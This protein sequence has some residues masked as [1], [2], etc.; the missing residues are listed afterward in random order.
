MS[1][2]T[3]LL[4]IV[5]A[6]TAVQFVA[7]SLRNLRD[8]VRL[9]PIWN[10]TPSMVRDHKTVPLSFIGGDTVLATVITY[11]YGRLWIRPSAKKQVA[12]C[13]QIVFL[14]RDRTARDRGDAVEAGGLI[15][16]I[17]SEG[18]NSRH[19]RRSARRCTIGS[20]LVLAMLFPTQDRSQFETPVRCITVRARARSARDKLERVPTRVIEWEIIYPAGIGTIMD[21]SLEGHEVRPDTFWLVSKERTL[22]AGDH[23]RLRSGGVFY[24]HGSSRLRGFL[25]LCVMSCFKLAMGLLALMTTGILLSVTDSYLTILVLSV[26]IPLF[27]VYRLF[28]YVLEQELPERFKSQAPTVRQKVRVFGMW[29]TTVYR[30]LEWHGSTRRSLAIGN[31]IRGVGF[32]QRFNFMCWEPLVDWIRRTMPLRVNG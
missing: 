28:R 29:T 17:L 30:K 16:A 9:V 23:D 22:H 1:D 4:T 21:S 25:S 7:R 18:E 12:L 19:I 8:V 27:L 6:F 32:W 13:D 11:I 3:E 24:S 31:R 10:V 2:L 20:E 26:V 15:Q 5:G 14:N